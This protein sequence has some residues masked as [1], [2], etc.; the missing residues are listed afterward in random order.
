MKHLAKTVFYFCFFQWMNLGQDKG[1]VWDKQELFWDVNQERDAQRKQR[2]QPS[3]LSV[4]L[5]YFTPHTSLL[6]LSMF[7]AEWNIPSVSEG[8]LSQ[9]VQHISCHV[10]SQPGVVRVCDTCLQTHN[11]NTAFFSHAAPWGALTQKCNQLHHFMFFFSMLSNVIAR[12][13]SHAPHSL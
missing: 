11:V 4:N 13:I 12:C 6:S 1:P 5:S 10:S 9:S 7:T 8:K 3:H 2:E